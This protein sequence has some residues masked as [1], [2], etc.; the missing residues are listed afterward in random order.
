MINPDITYN[1]VYYVES[2]ELR[3]PIAIRPHLINEYMEWEDTSRGSHAKI[4]KIRFTP[5]SKKDPKSIPDKI[6]I[7]TMEGE[8]VTLHK[9]TLNLYND[10]VKEFVAGKPDFKTDDELQNY[11]LNTNFQI[12]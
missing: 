4:K 2:S 3:N 6:E 5:F 10:K 11:Y 1:R 9:L 12:Y 8:I 7:V